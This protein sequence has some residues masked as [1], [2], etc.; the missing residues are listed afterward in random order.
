M[1]LL[2]I[3]N[4][5]VSYPQEG[6]ALEA[7]KCFSLCISPGEAVGLVGESGC[8]KTTLALTILKLLDKKANVLSGRIMFGKEELLSHNL[9][10]IRGK[11]IAL[12][13][14]ASQHAFNPVLTIGHQLIEHICCHTFL[15]KNEASLKAISALEEVGLDKSVMTSYP[16]QLSGGMR[17]RVAIAMALAVKPK[18]IIADECT[19]SLDILNQEQIIYLFNKIRQERE[20]AL[21]IISHDLSFVARTCEEIAVIYQGELVEKGSTKQVLHSPTHSY[22]KKLLSSLLTLKKRKERK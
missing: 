3:E 12:I 16:H 19:N 5:T 18:L 2:E 20:I 7:L 4:L 9:K 1:P 14:Q 8:G 21:L 22:T 10:G 11:K 6:T 15:T 17:Q 13:P